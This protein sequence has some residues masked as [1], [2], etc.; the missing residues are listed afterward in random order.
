MQMLNDVLLSFYYCWGYFTYIFF[1]STCTRLYFLFLLFCAVALVSV[2]F[3]SLAGSSQFRLLS[4]I[5]SF[6]PSFLLNLNFYF[7]PLAV[8][9]AAAAALSLSIALYT[10]AL[11]LY[12]SV[13]QCSLF[14]L[15]LSL[16]FSL[17][18]RILWEYYRNENSACTIY[19]Y[20]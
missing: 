17:W 1:I 9:V 2:L 16:F 8:V 10:F 14:T 19:I 20:K 4:L 13:V 12:C 7:F 5:F 3:L 6:L 15:C 11:A 18:K